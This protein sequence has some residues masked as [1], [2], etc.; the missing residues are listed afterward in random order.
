MTQC[1]VKTKVCLI[2]PKDLDYLQKFLLRV[3]DNLG[4]PNPP[5]FLASQISGTRFLLRV[6][7]CNIPRFYQILGNFFLLLFCLCWLKIHRDLKL[8]GWFKSFTWKLFQAFS[9]FLK[10]PFEKTKYQILFPSFI[11]TYAS[12]LAKEWITNVLYVLKIAFQNYMWKWNS[13]IILKVFSLI[14]KEL[15]PNP[16]S[17]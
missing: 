7:V 1:Q 4:N 12:L 3:V 15:F 16:I 14:L 10:N 2:E 11:Q 13:N 17:I 8:L 6:V 9:C 5:L